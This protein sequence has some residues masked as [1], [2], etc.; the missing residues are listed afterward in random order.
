MLKWE[1]I[2]Q[3]TAGT[4]QRCKVPNGWLVKEVHEVYIDMTSEGYSPLN[5]SGYTWTSTLAFIPDAHYEWE[6]E[7]K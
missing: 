4:L 6:I 7:S 2:K 1:K 5:G 3:D